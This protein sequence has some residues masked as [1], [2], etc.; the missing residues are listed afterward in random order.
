MSYRTVPVATPNPTWNQATWFID[1]G[2][3]TG[4]ASDQNSGL[5]ATHAV[6]SYNGGIVAKWGTTSPT[7]AQNTT[8]TWLS[9]VSA[10]ATDPVVLTP[11]LRGCTCTLKGTPQQISSGAFASA[12]SKNRATPQLLVVG[13]ALAAPIGSLIVN[14]TI[15]KAS[16]A[17]VYKL[18]GVSAT[19]TQPL[20]PATVPYSNFVAAP[21][22]VDMWVMGDTYAAFSLPSIQIARLDCT[23]ESLTATFAT[24]VQVYQL[25]VIPVGTSTPG[26]SNSQF[27]PGVA[28][29]ES[30]VV[31][32]PVFYGTQ[33]DIGGAYINV[34]FSVGMMAQVLGGQACPVLGGAII[35]A[36]AE[37]YVPFSLRSDV[38]IDS[39]HAPQGIVIGGCS[40]IDVAFLGNHYIAGTV[41][42]VGTVN[43]VNLSAIVWGP[44]TFDAEAT[45]RISYKT[46]AGAAA[47][48][49]LCTGGLQANGVASAN[50]FQPSSATWEPAIA[51][52]PAALD[53]AFGVAGFGGNAVNPGGATFTNQNP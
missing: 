29:V 48:T 51:L 49:F 10:T 2:N 1:P 9:S 17:F 8:L 52:T 30:S 36:V 21:A 32:L 22:E 5:D 13:L 44:G 3:V 4:N 33:D 23:Q 35:Q 38:I 14:T 42:Y 47:A 34:L 15:G 16:R 43:L 28:I 19:M 24:G 6:K 50:P 26:F 41:E 11:I 20:A 37:C 45:A 27:G 31:S 25:N 46:G 18:V 12:T 40:N 39:T 53:A 7:L